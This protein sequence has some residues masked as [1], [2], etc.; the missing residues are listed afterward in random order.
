M[1][2]WSFLTNHAHVLL[3]IARD[4][5]VR[6]RDIAATLGVTERSAYAVVNDLTE[7]GY[8]VKA[9]DGRRNR[10]EIRHHLPL[11]EATG[12]ERTIGELLELLASAGGDT[13][14]RHSDAGLVEP[15]DGELVE[16]RRS[17]RPRGGQRRPGDL[18]YAL[19][20]AADDGWPA[21]QLTEGSRTETEHPTIDEGN[22]HDGQVSAQG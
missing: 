3:C 18:R 4:P 17:S 5:R 21:G 14:S 13:R 2:E 22:L 1:G 19:D 20:R 6:L 12:R 7:S 15:G 16:R 10:Y 11:R 9:R 8:V